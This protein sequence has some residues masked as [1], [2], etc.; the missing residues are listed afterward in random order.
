MQ[1]LIAVLCACWSIPVAAQVTGEFYLEKDT[2]ARGEPVFLYFRLSNLGP[3]AVLLFEPDIDQPMCSGH[4]I[5]VTT[6]PPPPYSCLNIADTGCTINGMPKQ[7]PPLLPGQSSIQRVLLNF[8]HDIN[9]PGYYLVK[10]SHIAM[11]NL[12]AGDAG[13][14]LRFRVDGDAPPYPVAKLQPWVDQLTSIDVRKRFEAAQILASLAPR[15][16]EKTLLE[17]VGNPEFRRYAPLAL[18]RLNTP[19]S[20]QALSDLGN[21]SAPGPPEPIEAESYLAKTNER[22]C[23]PQL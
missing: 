22:M 4:L 3:N 8:S 9:T 20:L 10:A 21:A 23:Y 15:A 18:H 7:L 1:L 16:L 6:D 5:T 17:F 19:A 14:Y 2:F 12:T 13:A 11:P